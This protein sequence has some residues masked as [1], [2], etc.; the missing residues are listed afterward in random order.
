MCRGPSESRGI[1]TALRQKKQRLT[2]LP[3]FPPP[4]LALPSCLRLGW[5]FPVFATEEGQRLSQSKAW[6]AQ[7]VGT[8]GPER[9]M[10][11][12]PLRKYALGCHPVPL[13]KARQ[14]VS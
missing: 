13:A 3:S 4:P 9:G 1:S 5:A 10:D 12:G 6:D 14:G 11:G 7:H 2:G 8:L